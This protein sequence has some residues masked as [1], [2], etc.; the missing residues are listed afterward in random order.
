MHN[1]KSIILLSTVLLLAFFKL[2]AQ[3][4]TITNDEFAQLSDSE[5]LEIKEA[6]RLLTLEKVKLDKTDMTAR[7]N[8]LPPDNN[9][10]D[11]SNIFCADNGSLEFPNSSTAD[12]VPPAPNEAVTNSC[13]GSAP[14]PVWYFIQI[15]QDG[16]IIIEITQSTGAGGTG[17][18]L[19][20][21]YVCWGPFANASESCIDFS[22]GACTAD[23]TCTGTV[24]DCSF[25]GNAQETATIPNAQAGEYYMF[26]ITNFAGNAGF[27]TLNQTNGTETDSGATDCCPYVSGVNP[28][29]CEGAD[30]IIE[31]SLLQ[32]DTEYTITYNDPNP[33]SV[34][35]TSNASGVVQ[36]TGVSSGT[37]TNFNASTGG[38]CELDDI[39]LSTDSSASFNSLTVNGPICPGDDAIFTVNGTADATVTYTINGGA[40]QTVVLDA[41][42]NGVVTINGA[43]ENQTILLSN[44]ALASCNTPLTDTVVVEIL[45]KPTIGTAPDMVTC[46]IDNDNVESFDL[47]SQTAAILGTQPAANYTITYHLTLAAANAGTGALPNPFISELETQPIFVRIQDVSN[48]NCFNVSANAV[49]N[50]II[51]QLPSPATPENLI[52][53]DEDNNGSADFDLDS[54][55]SFILNNL[56]PAIYTVTYHASKADADAGENA[57]TSPYL[58]TS[59]PQTIYVNITNNDTGCVNSSLNFVI[60]TYVGA[61]ANSD[62][63]PLNISV[64]DD[65]LETD[66]DTTND[67]NTFDL[68]LLNPEI[69]DGQNPADFTISFYASE[70]DLN[71]GTNAI[72]NPN[73][74]NN[75]VN[76]Q[77]VYIRIDND[78]PVS[79][80]TNCF[81]STT[82]TL[83]VNPLPFFDLEDLYYLCINTNGTEVIS[84]PILDTEL[85]ASNHTFEWTLDGDVTVI[86]TDSSYTANAP[87]NYSVTATNTATGC[88]YTDTTVVVL[89][90]PPVLTAN[91]ISLAFS[92]NNIIHATAV[93]NGGEVSDYE[94]SLDA[95]P[96]VSN[97][98][99]NGSYTF[100]NVSAGEHTITARDIHGCGIS[101]TTVFVL[102]YP[103]YFTPNNDG[104]HDTWYIEGLENQPDAQ[105]RIFDRFGKLLKQVSSVGKGWD[106]VYNGKLLPSSDYWF[107]L[108]YREPKDDVRKTFTAHFALKR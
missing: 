37:Y 87:G 94:F 31:I 65:N 61:V 83:N 14:N 76:P 23:H 67:S 78:P 52:E 24:V 89:S 53:C 28:T 21:D 74:Y 25:S 71:A 84:D 41:S 8:M 105:I 93:T 92:S 98:P 108:E 91:L 26:L 4:P 103:L 104:Y 57:L 70:D 27:I 64:C 96:W 42:G 46:D 51:N 69:L 54:Q 63:E 33:Q 86:S 59:S 58:N 79:G 22:T 12:N 55:T 3:K 1:M 6:A 85:S 49:F 72:A 77:T 38:T 18:Q 43:T 15:A 2:E 81:G 45:A 10:C 48:A 19:D 39:T 62:G 82:A 66:G 7:L 40:D 11:K 30:G 13:L 5:R 56:D 68:T 32:P 106:G 73:S 101:S 35:L 17:T 100:D 80:D 44:I 20:V 99:D 34:T 75:T 102:D 60:E 90:S 29:T 95:G 36:I 50:L 16:E 9:T 47:G 107:T 97:L 88:E